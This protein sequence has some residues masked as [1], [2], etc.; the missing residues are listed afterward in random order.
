MAATYQVRNY[1]K[2]FDTLDEK[3]FQIQ[4]PPKTDLYEKPP[5]I[6]VFN[7]PLFYQSTCVSG[8]KKASVSLSGEWKYQYDQGGLVIIAN[9]GDGSRNWVKAGVELVDQQPRLSIMAKDR[10][11][12]WSLHPVSCD[13]G[14]AH[15]VFEK[16]TDGSLRVQHVTP[17]ATVELARK[18]TW[19]A[20]LPLETELWVGV[21]A[22]RP[23]EK[24]NDNLIVNFEHL[25]IDLGQVP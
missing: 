11:S 8:F 3:S 16:G 7:A 12:D 15:V 2:I 22:A 24:D 25:S 21:Y 17:Q 20:D 19:W 23:Y 18:I 4:G 1:D 6:H 5:S 9:K 10:W 14:R 13:S